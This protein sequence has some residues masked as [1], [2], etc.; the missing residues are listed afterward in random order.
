MN[1]LIWMSRY[2]YNRCDIR[3]TDEV[4]RVVRGCTATR[5]K[6]GKRGIMMSK[7]EERTGEWEELAKSWSGG[8]I[9]LVVSRARWVED[10]FTALI[11][12]GLQC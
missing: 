4:V 3:K 7:K 6:R 8:R 10:P 12:I 1:V 5:T 9:E 11:T 2:V